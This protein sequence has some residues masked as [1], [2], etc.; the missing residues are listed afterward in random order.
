MA[1]LLDTVNTVYN[2]G[3][4]AGRDSVLALLREPEEEMLEAI[5]N[6][7]EWSTFDINNMDGRVLAVLTAIHAALEARLK[8]GDG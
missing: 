2:N 5:N 4:R 3:F 7:P 6:C 1:D 8:G